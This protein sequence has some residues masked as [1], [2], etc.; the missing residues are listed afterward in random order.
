MSAVEGI[1][2]PIREL[3]GLGNYHMLI[4]Q[5]GRITCIIRRPVGASIHANGLGIGLGFG[6]ENV[7]QG[8]LRQLMSDS[9]SEVCEHMMTSVAD[10]LDSTARAAVDKGVQFGTK[11]TYSLRQ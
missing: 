5:P 10:L 8:S 4:A 2:N 9:S 7:G 6:L 1:A 3:A 11:N